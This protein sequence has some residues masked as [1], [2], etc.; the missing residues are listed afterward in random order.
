[1][2]CIGI[3]LILRGVFP[4]YYP[5][6]FDQ[7][8]LVENGSQ[9]AQG[10]ITLIG[11]RTGP[12]PLFTGPLIYY[13]TAFWWLFVP[14]VWSIVFTS[15]SIAALT[16][17]TLWWLS[18]RFA[19]DI[20]FALLGLWAF[21]PL[22]I[23]FDRVPWNPNL[24]LLASA[25]VFFPT[26]HW[27]QHRQITLTHLIAVAT[28][29]FLG[30]QA[31]FSTLFLPLLPILGV[32][33]VAA[34]QHRLRWRDTGLIVAVGVG[35]AV[36]FLPALLFDLRNDWLHLR[37]LL[38]L[39]DTS[40]VH[41]GVPLSRRWYETVRVS[42]ET[43]GKMTFA[44][45]R[46]SGVMM[47]GCM[48]AAWAVLCS[49]LDRKHRTA[50]MFSLGWWLTISVVFSL[51][52]GN[53]PEY[54]YFLGLP[55]GLWIWSQLATQWTRR[56][57]V[58]LAIAGIWA[59]GTVLTIIPHAIQASLNIGDQLQ[60][61]ATLQQLTHQEPIAAIAM[62][63]EPIDRLG[64]EYLLAQQPLSFTEAGKVVHIVGGE[65]VPAFASSIPAG[66]LHMWIDPRVRVDGQTYF[67]ANSAII[68][69]P[70]SWQL[71]RNEQADSIEA[72]S[73]AARYR[74]AIDGTLTPYQIWIV[75]RRSE[76][77]SL[78]MTLTQSFSSAR[79]PLAQWAELEVVPGT[80]GLIFPH[81]VSEELVIVTVPN[82]QPRA[83]AGLEEITS[84]LVIY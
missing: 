70:D 77:E 14:S 84:T 73:Y 39:L 59:I 51:Y 26:L 79:Y 30:F 1:M 48:V 24:T 11:P 65:H 43:I 72:L 64:L 4:G 21:S 63:I 8:Q 34:R 53:K 41:Q 81:P 82:D 55:A 35:L 37:G 58:F 18:R 68:R 25:L 78:V 23:Q 44:S 47:V 50:L 20:T 46:Y 7:L 29:G 27:V 71:L 62:D 45:Q 75:P 13:L 17:L 49:I 57:P 38:S 6:G 61:H 31:H 2:G 54:Y 60:V 69:H 16:G 19:P 83:V 42:F 12:A 56:T 52:S 36:S 3:A 22:L 66:K 40:V 32:V 80:T 9:I 28:G 5:L 67:V 74:V 10:D 33:S 15:L 76:T